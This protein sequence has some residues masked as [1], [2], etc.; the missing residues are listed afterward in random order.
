MISK[1][2]FVCE[3]LPFLKDRLFYDEN[4]IFISWAKT[5]Q[6]LQFIPVVFRMDKCGVMLKVIICFLLIRVLGGS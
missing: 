6:L 3:L 4:T 1:F 5:F 2:H